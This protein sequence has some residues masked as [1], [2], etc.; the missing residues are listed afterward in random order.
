MRYQTQIPIRLETSTGTVIL[1]PGD[2]FRPSDE[3]T[4][5]GL[6][7][8]GKVKPIKEVMVTEFKSLLGWLKQF[9]LDSDELKEKLPEL[10]QGIQK[11]LEK[12]DNASANED[13]PA[14]QSAISEVKGLYAEALFT[15]RQ[16]AIKVYSELLDCNLW[17]VATEKDMK[18]LKQQGVKEAIYTADEIK[19]LSSLGKDFLNG[20]HRFKEVFSEGTIEEINKKSCP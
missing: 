8:D 20:L 7:A 13:L 2:T 15:R 4:I 19:R 1:K 5:K 9:D 18:A 17:V 6:L 10:Y 12:I 3:N 16:I 11:A 14:F